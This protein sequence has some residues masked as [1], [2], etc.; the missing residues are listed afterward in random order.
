M[1]N[2]EIYQE[3][4]RS[5]PDAVIVTNN[6][7]QIIM[8]NDRVKDVFGYSRDELKGQMIELLVPKRYR[9]SHLGYRNCY[10][11]KPVARPMGGGRELLA[12]RKD[13]SEFFVEISLSPIN[14]EG[15][16][17]VLAAVR[18][19][20]EKMLVSQK[21]QKSLAMIEKKNR[22]LEQFAYVA[23]HD[24]KEPL[25]TILSLVN[26]LSLEYKE[27]FDE[28]AHEYIQLISQT[29][30]RM[31]A[32]IKDLL[33][34]SRVGQALTRERVNS[35]QLVDS[36]LEDMSALIKNTGAQVKTGRLPILNTYATELRQL[37]QNLIANA[38][39][40]QEPGQQPEIE[41]KAVKEDDH[42]QF[43]VS[44][45]GIGVEEEAREKIFRIFT[46]LHPRTTYE[47]TGIGLAQCQ[48]IVDALG[49][50]IWVV[51]TLGEGSTFYF[52][53]PKK[54]NYK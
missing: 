24:L 32:L 14:I 44:D 48:K 35:N 4:F 42:W 51:S 41:I 36:V 16:K 19:V 40:F 6:V 15:E 5:G 8:T 18:D 46:R 52:T 10:Q 53:I 49:G 20:T 11:H 45:N 21:L 34:Y 43:S 9:T 50:R 47:G 1:Y 3:V 12:L 30:E 33:D 7:G 54:R 22:E 37:F 25:H 17:L 39:K 28:R 29:S 31:K 26:L 38:I 23:S 2:D 13:G 27:R